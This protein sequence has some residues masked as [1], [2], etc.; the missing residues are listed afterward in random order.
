MVFLKKACPAVVRNGV[1]GKKSHLVRHIVTSFTKLAVVPTAYYN[2]SLCNGSCTS[3]LS[4]TH[5][6]ILEPLKLF[7]AQWSSSYFLQLPNPNC[8][9][10]ADLLPQMDTGKH[11]S[12]IGDTPTALSLM[13]AVE[14]LQRC[15]AINRNGEKEDT[16]RRLD[17]SN[18]G[19]C[20][21]GSGGS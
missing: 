20:P 17:S 8:F 21:L 12:R 16:F 18:D 11:L 5:S 2:F 4:G 14:A 13:M 1:R 3:D 19:V 7:L 6:S 15:V 9:T 10:S